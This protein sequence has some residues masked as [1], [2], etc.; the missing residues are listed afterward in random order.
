MNKNKVT[1]HK[2]KD[3]PQN[4]EVYPLWIKIIEV[5]QDEKRIINYYLNGTQSEYTNVIDVYRRGRGPSWVE[6]TSEQ[7]FLELL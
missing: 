5:H 3:L 6:I 2:W 7:A 1:Y 4:E